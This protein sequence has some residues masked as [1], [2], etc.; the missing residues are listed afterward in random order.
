MPFGLSNAP[1]TFQRALD[2]ILAGFKWQYVL[3]YFDDVIV[4]SKSI[5]EHMEH[6]DYTLT[7]LQQAGA[8]LKLSKCHFFRPSV[9]YLGHVIHPG[10]L[11]VSQKN[12]L[13]IEKAQHPTTRTQLR[14][15]LG[16]CN[17]YRKFVP[18]FAKIAS[19]LTD[20]LKKGQPD[21]YNELTEEQA[22]AFLL[23]RTALIKPP[24]LAL[25]KEGGSFI[26]DVDASDY[27]IGACLQHEQPD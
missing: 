14:S 20:L 12:I 11:A 13:S 3:V 1:A 8:T 18:S 4:Y 21:T 5:A 6:L 17:V 7:L 2:M 19:P 22:N 16:M 15:F 27:Q 26:L 23:L 9:D 25:P 24:I 10:K